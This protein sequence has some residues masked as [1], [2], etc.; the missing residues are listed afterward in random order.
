MMMKTKMSNYSRTS[1]LG[2]WKTPR[3]AAKIPQ[4]IPQQKGAASTC[5]AFFGLAFLPSAAQI[6]AVSLAAIFHEPIPQLIY[7]GNVARFDA[8]R[9]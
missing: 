1:R 8:Q 7:R 2:R 4:Q 6:G 9:F 5:S 3:T